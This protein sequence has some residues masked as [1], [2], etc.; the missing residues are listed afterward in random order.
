MEVSPWDVPPAG[1]V[2]WSNPQAIMV[3]VTP[4]TRLHLGLPEEASL[5]WPQ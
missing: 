2:G 5:P 1:V 3:P 4:V